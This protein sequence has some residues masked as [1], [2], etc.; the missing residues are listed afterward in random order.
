MSS[1][2]VP[3]LMSYLPGSPCMSLD[4]LLKQGLFGFRTNCCE[5]WTHSFDWFL[6][7]SNLWFTLTLLSLSLSL[8]RIGL[9]RR[10]QKIVQEEPSSTS[11]LTV[12]DT[13]RGF[14]TRPDPCLRFLRVVSV[15]SSLD[16]SCLSGFE[17][18]LRPSLLPWCDDFCPSLIDNSANIV[19][20]PVLCLTC[21]Y[22]S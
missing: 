12:F 21:A 19:S 4:I 8:W 5:S 17:F 2:E 7:V 20:R 9:E 11:L 14:L 3:G 16:S 10:A 18:D 6:V 13:L 22:V 1:S 15:C